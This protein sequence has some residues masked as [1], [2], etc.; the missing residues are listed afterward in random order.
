MAYLPASGKGQILPNFPSVSLRNTSP[1]EPISIR[2]GSLFAHTCHDNQRLIST[3]HLC[4]SAINKYAIFFLACYNR[5][6]RKN[7]KKFLA[8]A[9]GAILLLVVITLGL[10]VLITHG[11]ARSRIFSMDSSP[12]AP[13]AIVFGAGLNYD[14]SPTVV[15]QDRVSTAAELYFQGKVQKLLMTGDNR[16]LDYNEPGAMH[17]FAVQLGV[18]SQDIVRDYGGRRTYD[19]CYRASAIFGVKNAVL[20]TQP[21]HLP[22]AL[23]LCNNLNI[24]AHGVAADNL[25]L[26][27][28]SL[29][30]WKTREVFAT[31]MSF[32]DVLQQL[33]PPVMGEQ[34]PIFPT[35]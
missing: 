35:Q 6:M 8:N 2:I 31:L 9:I 25:T 24:E 30:I 23:F 18:P 10:P 27:R 15:L 17:D 13:V 34:E 33:P 12:S 26:P 3:V 11:L 32:W 4:T 14:G 20:V 1:P 16:F 19:S 21:Y 5:E 28:R 7:W 29:L 22:R